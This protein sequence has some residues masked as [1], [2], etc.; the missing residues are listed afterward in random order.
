VKASK[1]VLLTAGPVGSP[2]ILVHSGIGD[3]ATLT[4]LGV[5][6]VLHNPSVGQNLTDHALVPMAWLVNTTDTLD[7][8]NRN[9]TLFAQTLSQWQ[10][11]RTGPF[12][13]SAGINHVAWLRVPN[14]ATI[15]SQFSDPAAGQ[16]SAHFEFLFF[17]SCRMPSLY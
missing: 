10:Q 3:S 16:N 17:V 12:V 8:V 14:N 2:H 4:A 7:N 5:T 11:N 6:P 1:E 15:W 13:S 9:T